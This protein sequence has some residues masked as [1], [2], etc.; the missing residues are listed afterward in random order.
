MRRSFPTLTAAATALTLAS[1][2][3]T[4][5]GTSSA[6]GSV[7]LRIVAAEYGDNPANSSKP[8]WER[9]A[10]DF[11]RANPGVKV[12]VDVVSWNDVDAKVAQMVKDGKAPDIAQIGAYADYANAGKLYAADEILSIKTEADFL[13]PLAEA[14]KVRR[15]QYGLPFVSSTRLMFYNQGL[16]TEA[17]VTKDGSPWQPRT[18]NDLV[19]AAKKLKAAG[20]PTPFALPLGPEEAQAES[21]MWMLS[22]GGG[23]TN[24]AE[25]YAIDSPKNVKTFE[26]LRDK[27][28]GQGLTGPVEP[29][30]LDRQG[31]FDAFIHGEVGILNGHPTL[32]KQAQD[33]GVKIG[34]V[35]MPTEDGSE[36]TAMGVADWAMAFKNGHPKEA[37]HF[38]DYLYEAKNVAAFTGKY[39][40]LPATTSGYQEM[41]N[42][43]DPATIQLQVFLKALPSSRL[44]PVGKKSWAGVSQDMKQNIGKAVQPG[45]RPATVLG[46]IAEKARNAER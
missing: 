29:G 39:G 4:G 41:T 43:A 1:F 12:E 44:Y 10:A 22:G 28:V 26:F 34:V 2:T 36:P 13:A 5:C 38:L 19:A 27:M 42:S 35:P 40:L 24:D 6:A 46:E 9:L 25:T 37:G 7:T 33:K 30:K 3:L 16:L 11:E 21:M 18:W 14:G 31:A 23:Y 32:I 17:G 8:Y 45:S 15:T 20:V